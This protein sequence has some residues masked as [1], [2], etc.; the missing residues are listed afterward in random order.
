MHKINLFQFKYLT[1][2]VYY[3]LF[4]NWN[5]NKIVIGKIQIA[6]FDYFDHIKNLNRNK[7]IWGYVAIEEM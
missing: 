5:R 1:K 6:F 7:I 4:R 3:K 2:I